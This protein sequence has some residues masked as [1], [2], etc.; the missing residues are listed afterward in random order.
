[1]G[2]I[3]KC[4]VIQDKQSGMFLYPAPDG[5]VGFTKFLHNA[6]RCWD[7]EEAVDT[8]HMNLGDDFVISS[9]YDIDNS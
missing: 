3:A 6:G 5:D 9:F 1:M 2:R 4:W 8:A 7:E